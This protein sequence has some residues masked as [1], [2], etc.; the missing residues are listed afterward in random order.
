MTKTTSVKQHTRKHP[1]KPGVRVPVK[2]HSREIRR[3]S[4]KKGQGPLRKPAKPTNKTVTIKMWRGVLD[5]VEGLPPG[6]DYELY[7]LDSQEEVIE[8]PTTPPDRKTVR[9]VVEG[10]VVQDVQNV[11]PS[12][13]YEI[14][15]DDSLIPT[16]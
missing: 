2:R 12:M 15:D 13:M 11:P 8:V 5:E 3:S 9:I 4:R 1:T 6:W 14:K 7:D 16:Y 10:G